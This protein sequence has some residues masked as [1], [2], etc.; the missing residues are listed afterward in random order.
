[1][2]AG[3][4]AAIIAA[5]AGL[6]TAA[7]AMVKQSVDG[8]RAVRSGRARDEQVRNRTLLERVNA[9][10]DEADREG[11]YRRVISEYASALRRLLIDHGV[12][13]SLIPPWP[14]R[15]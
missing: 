14:P 2:K 10:E 4:W 9:A 11:A 6:L 13:E 15:P 1:M 7:G 8:W 5:A 3:E 12:P